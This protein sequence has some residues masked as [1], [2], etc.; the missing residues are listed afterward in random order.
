MVGSAQNK[1]LYSINY[2]EFLYQGI[3][4]F[5]R[6]AVL[7]GVCLLLHKASELEVPCKMYIT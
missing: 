1:L 4:S 3:I 2:K 6:I 5:G 7:H